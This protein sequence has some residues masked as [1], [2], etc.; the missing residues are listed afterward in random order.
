VEWELTEETE[1]LGENLP[2]CHIV[3]H[4]SHVT[5][6][7][8]EHGPP[9]CEA[10]D[11]PFELWHGLNSVSLSNSLFLYGSIA[12]VDLGHVF[13]FLIHSQSVWLLGRGSSPSRGHYLHTEHTHISMPR[14]GFEPMIPV[15]EQEKKVHVR[16]LWPALEQCI[17]PKH[18]YPPIG[19]KHVF[20]TETQQPEYSPRWKPKI[21]CSFAVQLFYRLHSTTRRRY[22]ALCMSVCMC[23]STLWF[24]TSVLSLR[25]INVDMRNV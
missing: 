10:T 7:G 18:R 6:S 16:P 5:W 17:P 1:V 20:I 9:R 25:S 11:W 19:L 23:V 8:N 22:S 21:L 4:K 14:M 13:S 24:G 15:F 2:Q 12:L 3:H